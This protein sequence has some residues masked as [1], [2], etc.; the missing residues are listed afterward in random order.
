MSPRQQH[1]LDKHAMSTLGLDYMM[2]W[3][4][5]ENRKNRITPILKWLKAVKSDSELILSAK[6]GTIMISALRYS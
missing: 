5:S 4:D 2:P 6:W 3:E 1:F